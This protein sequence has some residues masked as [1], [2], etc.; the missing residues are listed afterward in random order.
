MPAGPMTAYHSTTS[1]P[2]TPASATVGTSGR[3]GAR[4]A[5]VTAIARTA[6]ER[7]WGSVELALPNMSWICP[8]ARSASAGPPPR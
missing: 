8:P 6:P 4:R 7:T 2:G 5:E 1:K 3:Y